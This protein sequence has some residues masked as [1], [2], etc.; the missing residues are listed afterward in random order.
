M[1][2]IK[3]QIDLLVLVPGAETGGSHISEI[4]LSGGD[5]QKII[6]RGLYTSDCIQFQ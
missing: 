1:N 3:E 6:E 4:P 5:C 2:P